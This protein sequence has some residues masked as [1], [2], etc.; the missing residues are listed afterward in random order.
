MDGCAP[1]SHQLP[2]NQDEDCGITVFAHGHVGAFVAVVTVEV[3]A[4]AL[5][6]LNGAPVVPMLPPSPRLLPYSCGPPIL[7]S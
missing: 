1:D 7:A 3:P 5:L 4:P 2:Q 6:Y